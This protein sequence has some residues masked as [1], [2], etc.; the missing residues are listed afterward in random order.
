MEKSHLQE[1]CH[2]DQCGD[3]GAT[4]VPFLE[5]A[6]QSALPPTTRVN[7]Q[8]RPSNDSMWRE[9]LR[10]L[11]EEIA[12]LNR[13]L[14]QSHRSLAWVLVRRMQK[15]RNLLFRE[16]TPSGRCWSYFSRFVRTAITLGPSVAMWKVIEKAQGKGIR[17]Q[18]GGFL[19][20]AL[21][22]S[23]Q[24]A[25][26]AAVPKFEDLPWRFLGA[27]KRDSSSPHR[28]FNV[29]LV[30]HSACRTGAPHALLRL[31]E[32]LTRLPG[33]KC[34][35]VL[36]TAGELADSFARVAPTLELQS[37]LELGYPRNSLPS[38][39]ASRF[40]ALAN[41]GLAVCNTTAVNDFHAAFSTAGVPVLSWI[42]ELPT[43]IEI[44]GGRTAIERIRSASSQVIVP[45]EVVRRALIDHYGFDETR[46][47]TIY[48]GLDLRTRGLNREDVRT[49]IRQELGLPQDSLI[50]LG[51][52]TVDSRKGADLFVQT[53]RRCLSLKA[54]QRTAANTWF[55]WVGQFN[56]HSLQRWLGHDIGI[57][58]LEARVLF[59]GQR[60]DT[61]PH[62]MAADLFL[63]TSR[64]DPCP[65]SMLEAMESGLPVVCFRD[66][67]GAEEVLGDA[68]ICVPYLDLKAMGNEVLWLLS[69]RERREA[70]GRH[71]QEKI[72]GMFTWG[73]F[74]PQFQEILSSRYN[75]CLDQP[76]KV[77]V[78]VPNFRH[79]RFLEERMRSIFDQTL[80]PHEILFLD[81]ASP[82]DSLDV[83]R[84]LARISPV[85][86]RIVS[87]EQN[88][89]S[90]FRQ[91]IK[92][93]ELATGD[94]VW[95][96]ESDD[97]CD[98]EFLECLVPQFFDPQVC[99]AYC[100]SAVIGSEGQQISDHFHEHTDDISASRWRSRY[101]ATGIEEI[102]VAL[103]QKNT[104][105]NASAVLFRRA[106]KLDYKDELAQFQYAGDWL[107]Y[108]MHLRCG[109]IAYLPQ[110][111]NRFRRHELSVSQQAIR[112]NLH[113]EET[114]SVRGRIFEEFPVSANA[115]A[116]SLGQ[117][118]FEY[119]FLTEKYGLTRPGWTSNPS[120]QPALERIRR[121]LHTRLG[122]RS[123]KRVLMIVDDLAA[124]EQALARIHL[125][126]RLARDYQVYL[127]NAQPRTCHLAS[128]PELDASVVFIEGSLGLTLWSRESD[129][130]HVELPWGIRRIRVLRELIRFHEIDMIHAHTSRADHLAR[131]LNEELGLPLFS[132][133]QAGQEPRSY[134]PASARIIP[135]A[136]QHPARESA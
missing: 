12:A 114:L 127:C 16:G 79:A 64:E 121:L 29:L 38:L 27:K 7:I 100:Q 118:V 9:R 53:A 17:L 125:A 76:P 93:L 134:R 33:L 129:N 59:L 96:A 91:W 42:H 83:A 62:F 45:A 92:G 5:N 97:C 66:A 68:G 105:P 101:F 116:R 48:N 120:L 122:N 133:L 87:N 36:K 75:Y 78:I 65:F 57:G 4:G 90:T 132:R 88:S 47:Q 108:A 21:R 85:P 77:S 72:R 34:F 1:T 51:C 25:P 82:D 18:R 126:S 60:V 94:L 54:D 26:A 124:D 119:D 136:S 86:M 6:T 35:V 110:A 49:R 10:L 115:I 123:L 52:G 30:A 109:K 22:G 40:R 11:E 20:R 14:E 71:G 106:P 50:V 117:A 8:D 70:M 43:A 112:G 74:L 73:R 28:L 37:L 98:P 111:L 41:Q 84:R 67:G 46:V 103:S 104:I 13:E 44:H 2:E 131:L 69:D 32:E 55:V 81:D 99:L 39:I 135:L 23:R 107:F 130:S 113:A 24:P 89:G 61:T 63:L 80:K 19:E 3:P 56:D 128:V 31:V 95:I 102:E 58:G 15:A